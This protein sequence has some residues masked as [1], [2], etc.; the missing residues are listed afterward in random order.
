M[1]FTE[2]KRYL[3]CC[4]SYGNIYVISV[5]YFLVVDHGID[6]RQVLQSVG[7]SH[8]ERRHEP[9]LDVVRLHKSIFVLVP[10]LVAV[11]EII[12]WKLSRDENR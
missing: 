9:Q 5:D 12:V 10:Q 7:R 11:T 2:T 3:W 4:N 8:D 1:I 6:D